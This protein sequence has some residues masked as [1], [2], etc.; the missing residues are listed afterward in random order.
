MRISVV[1]PVEVLLGLGPAAFC[2]R[3]GRRGD[4][5][6]SERRPRLA[7][8]RALRFFGPGRL[9]SPSFTHIANHNIIRGAGHSSHNTAM[10]S[11]ESSRIFVRGLPSKFT[12]DDVRKHFSK[13]PITDVKFFPARRI[14]YVGYKT[15]EDASKAIKYFNKSF[16]R[17]TKIYVEVARPVSFCCA[18]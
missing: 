5:R 9:R 6:R 17:M 2:Q 14:G 12:E 1:R 18:S 10:D 11:T 15:P 16:I 4:S 8:C 7:S 13:F 3:L